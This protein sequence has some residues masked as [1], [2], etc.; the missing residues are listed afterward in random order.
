MGA[1]LY[2]SKYAERSKVIQS[3]QKAMEKMREAGVTDK[4]RAAYI[5]LMDTVY[6]DPFYYFRDSYN[7][8]SLL[9]QLGLSW[10]TDVIPLY[11]KRPTKDI[12]MGVQACR[13]LK[14]MLTEAR[15]VFVANMAK[16]NKD[17]DWKWSPQDTPED[18]RKYFNNKYDE[19]HKFLDQAIVD[20]GMYASL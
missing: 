5:T 14:K 10:W 3:A 2:N 18:V 1:D 17:A 19:L 11:L 7:N 8:S 12:N 16:L 4:N 9:W 15:P 13:K 6:D 20:G